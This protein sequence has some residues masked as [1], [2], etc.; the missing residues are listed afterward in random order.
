M[1]EQQSIYVTNF[2]TI[3]DEPSYSCRGVIDFSPPIATKFEHSR[4]HNSTFHVLN[5]STLDRMNNPGHDFALSTSQGTCSK[6]KSIGSVLPTKWH[7]CSVSA[8]SMENF[9]PVPRSRK[10]LSPPPSAFRATQ[11]ERRC[12][13]FLRKDC[14]AAIITAE[15]PFANFLSVTCRKFIS[16]V[17][18]SNYRRFSQRGVHLLN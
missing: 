2:A 9:V 14:S 13:S 10:F 16:F 11:C 1:Q 5:C 12:A 4:F 15:S 6:H 3:I 18:C 7:L 17:G 8:F